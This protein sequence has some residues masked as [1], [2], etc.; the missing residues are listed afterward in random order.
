M[1]VKKESGMK[2][3]TVT[4]SDIHMY[5][6]PLDTIIFCQSTRWKGSTSVFT[7]KIVNQMYSANGS[8]HIMAMV[9]C[10]WKWMYVLN[11]FF[12]FNIF[13]TATCKY[14]IIATLSKTI[15]TN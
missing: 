8:E 7:F 9:F 3:Q 14:Y 11:V 5:S 6:D 4:D 1:T 15:S 13:A 12:L 2:W 10:Q